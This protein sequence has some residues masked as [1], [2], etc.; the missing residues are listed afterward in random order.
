MSATPRPTI[1]SLARELKL[2]RTSVSEALRNHPR[3]NAKTRERVQ[4]AAQAA[5]YRVNPLASSI[6]SELRR[7][8]L[9]AFHGVLAVVSLEEPTRPRFPGPYWRDLLHGASDR[10]EELG[11]KLERF[12]VGEQGVS[13][14]RLDTILQSRGIRGVLIMPAWRRPDFSHLDW[15]NYTG[16]YTDYLIDA[17]ALHSVCPDHP[18][19]MMT[20]LS[21]L[22]ELG[23]RRPG[24]VLQAQESVRLQHRWAGAF[25]AAVQIN[26][27]FETA[28]PPL[29]VPDVTESAFS[30]WFRE[31]RPDVVLGHRAEIVAWMESAG[32]DVPRTHGFCCLN[33]SINSTPCA[34]IDQQPY[35]IGERGIETVVS[36]LHRNEYGIP[37][38]PY[39]LTV[40]SRWVEGPTLPRA[41]KVTRNGK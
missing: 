30:A 17:P 40:P 27:E 32:A 5:G 23:Y 20:A 9:A 35:H 31:Y 41:A 28:I 8:R 14:H 26:P 12:L 38:V 39:N 34:G 1:R 16:V 10:A 24:L 29:L 3:V 13:V 19:S 25:L 21:R 2:S 33:V 22:R 18:R 11:F 4:A 6:L 15:T 36:Q 7:T 37:D